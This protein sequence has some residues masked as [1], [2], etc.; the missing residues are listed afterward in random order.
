MKTN[1]LSPTFA[2]Y[3][4]VKVRQLICSESEYDPWCINSEHPKVGDVGVVLEVLVSNNCLNKYVV[5]SCAEDGTSIWLSNF[6][7]EEIELV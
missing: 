1:K 5:E 6:F 2:A 4:V 7:E 3:S